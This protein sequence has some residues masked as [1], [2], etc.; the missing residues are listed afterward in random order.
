MPCNKEYVAFVLEQLE[1]LEEITI[2]SMMG[3]YLL[4]DKGKLFGGI[5]NN[6]FLI[7][8]TQGGKKMMPQGLEISP[9]KGAKPM[10]LVEEMDD[11]EFLKRLVQTTCQEL[12]DKKVK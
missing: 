6:Q 8:I 12:P 2:R 1:L 7:K 10:L 11:K 3:E 4:Y 9:Y 5:Y